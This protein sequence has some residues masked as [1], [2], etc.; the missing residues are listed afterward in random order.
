MALG[1]TLHRLSVE[2]TDTDRGV[3]RSLDLRVAQHPSE[4]RRFLA[5]RIL[6]LCLLHEK[7]LELTPAGLSAD[8]E[9]A[10]ALR[11]P[12][13]RILLWMDVGTPSAGRLHRA[14]KLARRVV[15]VVY[16]DPTALLRATAGERIHRAE[17]IEVVSLPSALLDALGDRIDRGARWDVVHTGGHLYVTAR[18][19]ALEGAVGRT[20]LGEP[21]GPRA[22][23]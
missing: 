7:G 3:F 15:V 10:A 2:L 11:A 1:A 20:F 23:S 21:G 9:P 17:A 5:A 4:T 19:E 14:S 13:G 22:R 18:G 6:G 12:D 16:D 8:D